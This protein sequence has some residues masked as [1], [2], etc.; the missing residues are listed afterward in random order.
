MQLGSP[1]VHSADRN[2]TAISACCLLVSPEPFQ[3]CLHFWGEFCCLLLSVL[4]FI[5]NALSQARVLVPTWQWE[6]AQ[7]S[8][9]MEDELRG[10]LVW[11]G[12]ARSLWGPAC[13]QH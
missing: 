13:H 9:V 4:L 3:D 10:G 6:A 2:R 7:L 1:D 11:W 12:W 8:R 5:T